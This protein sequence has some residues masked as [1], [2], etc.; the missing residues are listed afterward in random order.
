MNHLRLVARVLSAGAAMRIL[1]ARGRGA[2]KEGHNSS[3]V[4][5]STCCSREWGARCRTRQRG[6]KRFR[7]PLPHRPLLCSTRRFSPTLRERSSGAV[8]S[9]CSGSRCT[10]WVLRP[11]PA[12]L[13]KHQKDFEAISRQLTGGSLIPG[14]LRPCASG[15]PAGN[16]HSRATRL[17]GQGQGGRRG[18]VPSPRHGVRVRGV[19]TPASRRVR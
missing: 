14:V 18:H 3:M 1:F 12:D 2:P 5:L 7:R 15:S 9:T 11:K 19:W 4:S 17:P 10:R 6:R 13:P 8:R 16:R